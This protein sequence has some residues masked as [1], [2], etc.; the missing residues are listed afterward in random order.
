MADL[1]AKQLKRAQQA[2]NDDPHFRHL[3]NIDVNMA[4]KV[5]KQRFLVVF[6]GFSCSEVRK[7]SAKEQQQADFSVEMSLAQWDRYQSECRT[8]GGANLAQFDSVEAVIQA[9]DPRK[10]LEFLR[11]HTSVQAFFKACVQPELSLA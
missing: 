2:V 6:V 9:S 3:G 4:V 5:D 11:Y 10:K 8:P 7:I 1:S